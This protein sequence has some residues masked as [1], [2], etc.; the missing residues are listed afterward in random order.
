MYSH[1]KTAKRLAKHHYQ[2]NPPSGSE[3]M[4]SSIYEYAKSKNM[5]ALCI[6]FRTAINIIGSGNNEHNEPV[7]YIEQ[8]DNHKASVQEL[9]EIIFTEYD[10]YDIFC[11]ERIKQTVHVC[12]VKRN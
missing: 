1:N 6:E 11:A 3:Y 4:L 5:V 9:L 12:L 2:L 10:N 7:I 8:G